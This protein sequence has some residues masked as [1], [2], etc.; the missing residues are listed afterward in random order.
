MF[1]TLFE[2]VKTKRGTHQPWWEKWEGNHF[3]NN[4]QFVITFEHGTCLHIISVNW[5]SADLHDDP[6]SCVMP[7]LWVF[8]KEC[9]VRYHI[10]CLSHLV[11]LPSLLSCRPMFKEK[12]KKFASTIKTVS[13]SVLLSQSYGYYIHIILELCF[14]FHVIDVGLIMSLLWWDYS[15]RHQL[16]IQEIVLETKT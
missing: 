7:L 2:L 15:C 1:V 13:V 6:L 9:I 12:L 4:W 16:I 14:E 5:V 8:Q 10:V 3:A 11:M